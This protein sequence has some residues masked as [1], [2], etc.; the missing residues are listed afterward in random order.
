[1]VADVVVV[2]V[3]FDNGVLSLGM[4]CEDDGVVAGK[5]MDGILEEVLLEE[6]EVALVLDIRG[7]VAIVVVSGVV[8]LKVVVGFFVCDWGWSLGSLLFYLF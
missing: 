1:M 3:D 4:D 2:E 8:C 5:V 7:E 6:V